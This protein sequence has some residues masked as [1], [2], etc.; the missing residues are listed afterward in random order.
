MFISF[1]CLLSVLTNISVRVDES[2]RFLYFS[3]KYR[4]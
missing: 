3:G 4:G 2:V 1:G